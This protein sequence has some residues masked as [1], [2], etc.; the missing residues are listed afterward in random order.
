MGESL[1]VC[2]VQKVHPRISHAYY[3]FYMGTRQCDEKDRLLSEYRGAT[4]RYL[5]A[6]AELSRRIG[7]SSLDDYSKLHHG[8]EAGRLRSIE[9]LDRLERHI[10]EHLC[11]TS[12]LNDH[13]A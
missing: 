7:V 5:T 10:T 8:A 3:A 2:H 9:T 4:E 1:C 11:G 12:D 6:V 13:P